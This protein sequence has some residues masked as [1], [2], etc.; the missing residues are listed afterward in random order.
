VGTSPADESLATKDTAAAVMLLRTDAA[1]LELFAF[2]SPTPVAR[3]AASSGVAALAWAVPDVSVVCARLGI[4]VDDPVRCPDGT[5]VEL[6]A[7]DSGPTGLI[8]VTV[9]VDDPASHRLPTV[10]GP[11]SVTVIGGADAQAARPVDL[12]VNHL[13]LDVAGIDAVRAGLDR[14]GWHHDVAQ[15]SGGIAA[16]Y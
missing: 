4:G 1:F 12:G 11:V 16:V 9:R 6:R 8:G 15:S 5:P 14:V 10:P 13:C 7:A 3:P 2:S